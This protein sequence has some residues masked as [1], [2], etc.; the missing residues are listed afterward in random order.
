MSRQERM[1]RSYDRTM[2]G[3]YQRRYYGHSGFYNFGYWGEGADDQKAASE[4][5]VDL[6]ASRLSNTNGRIL[7]VACGMGATSERLTRSFPADAITGINVSDKQ[8]DMARERVP[9]AEF[10]VMD[11]TKLAFDP[12]S[13][14]A[15]LCVEAAFHFD[16]RADFLAEAFRVLKPGGGLSLSDILF[17]RWFSYL[18]STRGVPRANLLPSIDSYH[19]LM[20]EAGFVDIVIDDHTDMTLDCFVQSLSRWPDKAYRDG[21]MSRRTSRAARFV[22]PVIARYFAVICRSYLIVSAR[23]PG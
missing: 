10:Q 9:G 6:L 13:F 7:D 19:A 11:A 17:K 21:D 18:P 4:A 5:L 3:K 2:G 8:I 12:E 15:V 1:V 14:D 23:K 16:T 20:T 22:T